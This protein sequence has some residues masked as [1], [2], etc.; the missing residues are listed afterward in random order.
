MKKVLIASVAL[1]FTAIA[2]VNAQV[3]PQAPVDKKETV[4]TPQ[5]NDQ[6]TKTPVKPEALPDAVKT[7]IAG[8]DYKGWVASSA[9]MIKTPVEHYEVVLT[10][11]K[12]TKTVK[13]ASDGKVML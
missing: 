5:T 8:E 3:K 2:S 11:D 1:L 9:F 7:T 6:E 13:F 12:E 10:K 4:T